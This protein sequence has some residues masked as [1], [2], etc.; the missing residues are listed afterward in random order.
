MHLESWFLR[1]LTVTDCD[2]VVDRRPARCQLCC[3]MLML[4]H[5]LRDAICADACA[6]GG[7]RSSFVDMYNATSNN[8]TRYPT[9]LGQGREFA[10]AA[11]LAS[12]L[13]FFAGGHTGASRILVC[14]HVTV[15][16]A[17]C[18]AALDRR[19]A[20]CRCCFVLPMLSC[21]R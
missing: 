18:D 16:R 20:R 13:V 6:S 4:S 7:G 21:A 15:T 19:P 3:V 9:G 2:D 12:G 10:A 11:S 8:W 17:D 5:A 14:A 1:L